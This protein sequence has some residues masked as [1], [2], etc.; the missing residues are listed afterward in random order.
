MSA[1]L[2]FSQSR[3]AGVK[4]ANPELSNTD[5]SR[6]LGAMWRQATE[7]EKREY[8]DDEL[9]ERAEYNKR[10]K[11]FREEQKHQDALN[12]TNHNQLHSS[13]SS[14]VNII[15]Q[16]K[17]QRQ[18]EKVREARFVLAPPS[19]FSDDAILFD[20]RP[21][22]LRTVPL[23][24]DDEQVGHHDRNGSEV[25]NSR[26]RSISYKTIQ[27]RH[28]Y[29]MHPGNDLHYDVRGDHFFT[30]NENRDLIDYTRWIEPSCTSTFCQQNR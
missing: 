22:I 23:P 28:S 16:Q 4:E 30:S 9:R 1:F 15:D 7:L 25:S 3:R 20:D 11:I 26:H 24:V 21:E 19:L 29:P 12:R 6:L 13:G 18:N 14:M 17:Q 10:T 8:V 27:P 2:K 5:I